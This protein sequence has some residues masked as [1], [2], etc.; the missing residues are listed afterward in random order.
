MI[1]SYIPNHIQAITVDLW[2][3]LFFDNTKTGKLYNKRAEFIDRIQRLHGD[4]EVSAAEI[5]LEEKKEFQLYE[6]NG[7][8]LPIEERI[9]FLTRQTISKTEIIVVKKYFD[10]MSLGYLPTLNYELFRSLGYWKAKQLKIA[11]LSNTGL[12]SSFVTREYLKKYHMLELFDELLFSEEEMLCKPDIC[13]FYR[14][15]KKMKIPLQN[16][17]HIGDSY[18][19]DYI[20]ALEAGM[21][22]ILFQGGN[23]YATWQR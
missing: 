8:I 21:S 5:V 3:T 14:A 16:I 2:G 20:P 23:Y 10:A 17:M 13:F 6:N 19:N 12:I 11:L 4:Y 7:I 18:T 22:A 9:R 15:S 1:L